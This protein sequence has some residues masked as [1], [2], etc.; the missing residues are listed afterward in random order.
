MTITWMGHACFMLESGGF[1]VLLDPFK[2]VPGL[3]DIEA[4]AD[5]V[6]CSHGHFDH[7]WTDNITLSG[8]EDSPF[9][10]KEIPAFHDE[11]GGTKRGENMIRSLTAEGVSVVHLGDLGHQL[12]AEQV[13]AIGRCD[14]LLIP[15]GGT[16]TLDPAEAKAVADALH[17]RIIVPMHY[18]KGG[19]GFDVLRTVE[20]FTAQYPAESV[21]EYDCAT[22]AVDETTPCQVAVLRV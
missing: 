20:E 12:S 5:A 9:I 19:M 6:Y 14:A 18:R 21:K 13:A 4:E 8:R 10:L 1:R 2:E 16:Y 7:C 17:P 15:V 22:L 3:T 11:V